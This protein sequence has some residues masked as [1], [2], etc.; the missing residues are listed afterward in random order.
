M[1][2]KGNILCAE[3]YDETVADD[4]L[5]SKVYGCSHTFKA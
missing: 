1:V 3:E 2:N 4:D 5:I